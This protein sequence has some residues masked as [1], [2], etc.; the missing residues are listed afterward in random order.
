[1]KR[2]FPQ[3]LFLPAVSLAAISLLSCVTSMRA[4][5]DSSPARTI[6]ANY[7]SLPLSFEPNRGQAS[8]S[9]QF[10]AHGQ[11][12]TLI[13]RDGEAILALPGTTQEGNS[14]N[15]SHDKVSEPSRLVSLLRMQLIGANANPESAK[16]EQLT[17]KSNY[18]LGSNPAYWRTG[19]PNYARIRYRSVYPGV[20]LVYYG[21]QRRLEYDFVVAPGANPR[22]I[23]MHFD[24]ADL[25]LDPM[26]N[27]EIALKDGKMGLE[28]PAIYQE[29][30]GGRR[31]VS[32]G[33]QLLDRST[34]GFRIGVYDRSRPLIIDPVLS[35]ST[36]VDGG[37]IA[38]MAVDAT[39]D[40]Y[41]TGVGESIAAT[42]GAFQGTDN[43]SSG[44]G[45]NAFVTKLDP[46][47]T[48]A[49]YSTYIGG[50]GAYPDEGGPPP[51]GAGDGG[52]GIAVDIAGNAYLTGFTYSH[53]FPLKNALQS[54][55]NAAG[56]GND[57][58]FVAELNPT[59]SALVYSTYLGGSGCGNGEGDG[60]AGLALDTTG[61]AY[62]VGN[63][64]SGDFP[65]TPGAYQTTSLA[66]YVNN[67]FVAKISP[68]GTSLVYSTYLAG[69]SGA[70]GNGV[71][72]DSSG[73]AYVTGTTYSTDF[74]VTSG[75]YQRT[76]RAGYG[77]NAFITK[78]NPTGSA[79]AYSTYLGGSGGTYAY[80]NGDT[81]QEG[82]HGIAIAVDG[83]GNAY[84][85][86]S[87]GSTDFPVT[88]GAFQ[89]RDG[90]VLGIS[91]AF[92]TKL[93][94][95]GS[96]LVY[97]TYLGGSGGTGQRQPGLGIVELGDSGNAITVDSAGNA[98]VAGAAGSVDFPVTAGAVQPVN[99][100]A[101][102]GNTNAFIAQLNPTGA[103]LLYSTYLGGTTA[104]S[105][106]DYATGVAQNGVGKVYVAGIANSPDFPTT[107]GAYQA[108][109]AGSS[110]ATMLNL[111]AQGAAE[112]SIAPGNMT[113]LSPGVGQASAASTVTLTNGGTGAVTIQ[114]ISIGG[115]NAAEF[116]QT[117][118]CGGSLSA[119]DACTV[120]IT[121][122]PTI[123][124]SQSATLSITDDAP[125]SPQS[126]PLKGNEIVYP[127]NAS[128]SPTSLTFSL[129][130]VGTISAPQTATLTNAG[131]GPLNITS[132]SMGGPVTTGSG[133]SESDTIFAL[134]NDCGTTLTAGASCTFHVTFLG[135]GGQDTDGIFVNDNQ[136]NSPQV[137]P[138]AG[139][140][141]VPA[142]TLSAMSLTFAS[143]EVGTTSSAQSVT[144]TNTGQVPVTITSIAATGDFS[145]TNNCGGTIAVSGSCLISVTFMPTATGSRTA[146]ITI[147]DNAGGSPQPITLTGAGIPASTTS[148][149]KFLTIT[150]CR[151]ADTRNPA[152]AFGGPE[153]AGGSIRTFNIPQSACSIPSTAVA[154]SLN[155][156]VVPNTSL[157]YLTVWSEGES[158][159]VVSTL[160]SDGRVKANATI[161][162][163]GTNGGVSVYASDA[164][165]AIIDIN[166][167]FVPAGTSTGGLE[168]YTLTPCRIAD[169][170][171]TDG[172]LG[173]PFLSG[174][175]S[176]AFPILSSTCG[177]PSTA[178]AYSLNITAVPQGGLGY[179]TAWPSGQTQPVVSSLNATS[180]AVTANAAIVTAGTGGDVSIYVSNPADVVLDI[181]G[182][183][184]PPVTGGLSLYTATPCRV[185]D[186]RY[187][188]GAFDGVL[189]VPVETGVC[190]APAAAK[191][192]VLNATVV[193]PGGLGYLSLW[194]AGTT[195]PVVSTL[196]ASDG[197]ITSN[198]A[199]VGTSNGSVDAFSSN[200]TELILD[201]SN[202]FAP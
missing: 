31:T 2:A 150:P 147:T 54:G 75:A 58:A 85:T 12:Y 163:A 196:N 189:T 202:Y 6:A 104:Y 3:T 35:Y 98:Y 66:E 145:E 71:T 173:G 153:L 127:P 130:A 63:T 157:G 1:M 106:G 97:S 61:A 40:V 164:T 118:T 119:G 73:N 32:G 182:Y 81:T 181:N 95:T 128:F 79:P 126:I 51:T 57:N 133:R 177:I 92:I 46:T 171:N 38:A 29:T 186:T 8:S 184:A 139:T 30:N 111:G 101:A 197:A 117:N 107:A 89:P 36:Y 82:D 68:G 121:F 193:P 201:L 20:D 168:F 59:G 174:D 88:P 80:P 62:V 142:M 166:G 4:Q 48:T 26:G 96:A 123:A 5:S 21:N 138:L 112:L 42:A 154:Y 110:F 33:F 192:Y 179:L 176:R 159:P 144:L 198:M 78:L 109:G 55:N 45:G 24:G 131:Q 53:D 170:R 116:A 15:S 102:L 105:V 135:G 22:A 148:E 195:Q 56:Y 140:G 113:V 134:T 185:I 23:R 43:Y 191:A 190:T 169:T 151:I 122:T 17:A 155:V 91:N 87:A 67:A 129:Q 156:T 18:F 76:N 93:N 187:S 7:G 175:T 143:Q 172:P 9:A 165:Q 11:G 90:A 199:I 84:I 34:M 114:S 65:T 10:L 77:T 188:T 158:Q 183:F 103:G 70:Y 194:A 28:R 83:A 100:A 200:Q 41:V 69:S 37:T 162:A 49:I 180:G 13:L 74:P 50:S 60:A 16:E 167:Y 19:I 27:I 25:K 99:H 149:L 136:D 160:N 115:T 146:M 178:K 108:S 132:I 14:Q 141:V 86:G 161:T 124:G 120:S 72:V 39:G 137:L 125:G 64:C 47:G 52:A 44:Y 152:G 94:A